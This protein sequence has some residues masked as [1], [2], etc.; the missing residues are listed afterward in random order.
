MMRQLIHLV[1]LLLAVLLQNSVIDLIA[2]RGACPNLVLIYLLI[3]AIREQ[4]L[5]TT[6]YGFAV[7]LFQDA[8]VSGILGLQA[9]VKTLVGFIGG[10][11]FSSRRA[12]TWWRP[13]VALFAL[14]LLHNVLI[15]LLS[16][17][18]P[19]RNDLISASTSALYTAVVGFIVLSLVPERVWCHSSAFGE[20]P[21]D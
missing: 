19:N 7:G 4:R 21:Y 17:F 2:I 11:L 14:D 6:V 13:T 12:Q 8:A 1:L 15:A 3:I 18:D 10:T 16:S 5:T 20:E 9:F